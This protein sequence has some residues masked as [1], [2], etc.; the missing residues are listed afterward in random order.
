MKI[1]FAS[2]FRAFFIAVCFG[3]PVGNIA[4][5]TLPVSVVV[6]LACFVAVLMAQSSIFPF[7]KKSDEKNEKGPMHEASD[8]PPSSLSIEKS[9]EAKV[10]LVE[11]SPSSILK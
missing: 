8:Q 3:V 4:K 2:V 5:E 11:K 7:G 1:F 9:K 10:A 6:L